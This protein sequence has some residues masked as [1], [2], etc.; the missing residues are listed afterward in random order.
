MIDY[1]CTFWEILLSCL[2]VKAR[3]FIKEEGAAASGSAS[4]ARFFCL[5]HKR[6]FLNHE[7]STILV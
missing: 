7:S 6:D 3:A 4:Q 1:A 2:M 5:L